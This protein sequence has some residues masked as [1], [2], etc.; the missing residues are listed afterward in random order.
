MGMLFGSVEQVRRGSGSSQKPVWHWWHVKY[1]SLWNPGSVCREQLDIHFSRRTDPSFADGLIFLRFAHPQP[2]KEQA[3]GNSPGE[4]DA[5]NSK[6]IKSKKRY[7]VDSPPCSTYRS[8][9][10]LSV[11]LS[12][13]FLTSHYTGRRY[14]AL[15][16]GIDWEY[17]IQKVITNMWLVLVLT[18]SN[19]QSSEHRFCHFPTQTIQ[20]LR[21]RQS[22]HTATQEM[23]PLSDSG[24]HDQRVKTAQLLVKKDFGWNRNTARTTA[25]RFQHLTQV[26]LSHWQEQC[27]TL[28]STDPL[29]ALVGDGAQ[30]EEENQWWSPT[31]SLRRCLNIPTTRRQ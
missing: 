21:V 25:K 13:L 20:P 5:V 3:L 7:T 28:L 15:A 10:T 14:K 9:T 8:R 22:H 17:E 11:L 31:Q 18:S 19:P 2:G 6:E 30:T 23:R 4:M 29:S 1:E 24:C 16:F 26:H 27:S 12:L